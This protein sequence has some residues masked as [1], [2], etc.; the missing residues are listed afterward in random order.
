MLNLR[1][2]KQDGT[3]FEAR[4]ETENISRGGF[5]CTCTSRLAEGAIVEVLLRGENDYNLGNARVV[6]IVETGSA[7]PRYGFQFIGKTGLM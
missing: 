5:L 7:N 4:G 2:T 6:R 1:G 3:A